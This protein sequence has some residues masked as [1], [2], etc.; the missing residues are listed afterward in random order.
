[1]R[2]EYEKQWNELLNVPHIYIYGAGRNAAYL[3]D[4]VSAMGYAD[5]MSGFVVTSLDRNP[6]E[7]RNLHV[8]ESREIAGTSARVLVS[9]TGK[10]AHE[11]ITL[12]KELNVKDIQPVS[13][14][15]LRSEFDENPFLKIGREDYSQKTSKQQE[16]DAR[17]R[18]KIY[19]LLDKNQPYFG[20]VEPYQSLEAIGLKGGRP[21]SYRIETY[22]L[23]SLL[24]QNMDVLDIGCNLS[25]LDLSI[26]GSA[27]SVTGIEYEK[28]LADIAALVRN[29][30]KI[31]NTAV[32]QGDYK[33][34]YKEN[35]NLKQYDFICSFAV[36]HW[37]GVDPIEYCSQINNLLRN[38]GYVCFESHF[39][40]VGEDHDYHLCRNYF[41]ENRY[42]L[43][44][45]GEIED[46]PGARRKFFIV[47]KIKK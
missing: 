31:Q 6:S 43:I 10:A 26:A 22:G 23:K 46:M 13:G 39:S 14:L 34:W 35:K 8:I 2:A 17:I 25:F 44:K 19:D 20:A 36:H 29:Y 45:E 27:A 28:S 9:Q 33:Q 42:Q 41:L 38:G 37:I 21:T 5:R 12:L 18:D 16:Q 30:L 4:I 7:L 15:M 40:N 1:M 3:F 47:Q 24:N 11:I 32:W